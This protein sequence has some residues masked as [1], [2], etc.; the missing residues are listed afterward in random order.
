MKCLTWA[1][2]P[3]ILLIFSSTLS[4]WYS[5]LKWLSS[6]TPRLIISKHLMFSSLSTVYCQSVKNV[7]TSLILNHWPS[8]SRKCYH[9]LFMFIRCWYG[10]QGLPR[11]LTRSDRHIATSLFANKNGLFI[12]S[13]GKR[14]Q[15]RWAG[16]RVIEMD[17]ILD[18]VWVL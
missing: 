13:A 4:M 17:C 2:T 1:M 14:Q 3:V 10:L 11:F 18:R 6:K 5:Q 8:L 7:P 15:M 16:Q 12:F 9:A